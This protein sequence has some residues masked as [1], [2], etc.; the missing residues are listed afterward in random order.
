MNPGFWPP[1]S[2]IEFQARRSIKSS[3]L[4]LSSTLILVVVANDGIFGVVVVLWSNGRSWD[5]ASV[6]RLLS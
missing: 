4:S 3:F 6:Q 5:R 2:V 1:H